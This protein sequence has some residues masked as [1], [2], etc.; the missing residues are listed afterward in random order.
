MQSSSNLV[1]ERAY[2]E[3]GGAPIGHVTRAQTELTSIVVVARDNLTVTADCLSSIL[4][5][6]HRSFEIILVDNGSTEDYRGLVAKLRARNVRDHLATQRARRRLCARRAIRG[7]RRRAA[8]TW[9]SCTTT[10]S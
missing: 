6:T 3:N 2:R 8:S 7:W 5:S 1:Y 9:R 4:A 10:W